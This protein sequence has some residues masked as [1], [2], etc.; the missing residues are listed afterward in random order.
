MVLGNP[1]LRAGTPDQA[2]AAAA[3][4][5]RLSRARAADVLPYVEAARRAGATTLREL[6]AALTARGVPPPAGG[7]S[8]HPMQVKRVVDACQ[9]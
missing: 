6:A 3:V 8:W 2:R 1:R 5:Q 4:K 7:R 9:W